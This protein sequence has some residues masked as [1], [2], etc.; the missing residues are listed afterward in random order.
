MTI[1]VSE[2]AP[3]IVRGLAG[4]LKRA[5]AHPK[6]AGRVSKM[7]GVVALRSSTDAQSATIRFDRGNIALAPGVAGDADVVVTLDFN[8]R[9]AK[10]KIKGA[11][12][13]PLLA[14]SVGKVLEPPAGSWEE[15]AAAFWDFAKDE[16]RMPR[17]LLVVCTDDGSQ[18]Q[19]G[20]T[21]APEYEIHGSADA[22]RSMLTGSSVFVEDF[23]SGRLQAVGRF[24]HASVL[25]GR[26]FAWAFGEGR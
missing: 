5:A 10:P 11:V 24:E 23:L 6:L 21:G 7:K 4:T 15:E 26:A 19:F 9:A 8:D 2:D 16:P 14:L 3:P 17:S 12:F 22:L 1:E 13:H 25:A 20:E 18:V